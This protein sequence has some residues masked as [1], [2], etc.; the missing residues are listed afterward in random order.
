MRG[1]SHSPGMPI[2]W[3]E[4]S[5][6]P[7]NR[8]S[9][10]ETAAVRSTSSTASMCSICTAP[11]CSALARPKYSAS[12]RGR[13]VTAVNAG[14][15]DAATAARLETWPRKRFL[16]LGR[17]ASHHLDAMTPPGAGFQRPHH[18]WRSPWRSPDE[19]VQTGATCA[20]AAS[21][22]ICRIVRPTC[23][24]VRPYRVEAAFHN[25]GEQN[26]PSAKTFSTRSPAARFQLRA[27]DSFFCVCFAKTLLLLLRSYWQGR[28]LFP[29]SEDSIRRQFDM[30]RC[31]TILALFSRLGK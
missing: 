3:P 8:K 24:L 25:F 15:I 19:A 14:A 31:P 6:G 28:G 13:S 2:D 27:D 10:S 17:Q 7:I 4:G 1:C 9:R 12:P 21:S 26:W 20:P 23:S 16:P 5:A 29:G 30:G 22:S 11:Q 18:Q